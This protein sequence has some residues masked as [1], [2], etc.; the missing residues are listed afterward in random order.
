[1]PTVATD[2]VRLLE[3]K[4]QEI[5]ALGVRKIGLFGSMA[6]GQAKDES[7][8]DI[9]VQFERGRKSF[10]NLCDLHYLLKGLFGRSVDLVTDGAL[11]DR[12]ANLILPTVRYVSLGR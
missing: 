2:P 10:D 3:S 4:S 5:R 6:R 7:D 12:K 9:Y 1:M 8:V 11:N